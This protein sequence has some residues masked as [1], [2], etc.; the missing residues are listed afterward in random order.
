MNNKSLDRAPLWLMLL[1]LL[2]LWLLLLL[3]LLLLQPQL[4]AALYYR[5]QMGQLGV[6]R[7]YWKCTEKCDV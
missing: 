6:R 2:L 3:L 5:V 1:L 7:K 4:P